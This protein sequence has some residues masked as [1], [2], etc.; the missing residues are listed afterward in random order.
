MIPRRLL[1]SGP[2]LGLLGLL[3]LFVVLLYL[4]GQLQAFFTASNIQV[5]LHKNSI[6]AVIALGA[7][8]VIVSGGIDLSVGS[9]AALVT[10]VIMQVYRLVYDGPDVVLPDWLLEWLRERG[11]AWSGTSSAVWASLVAVPAGLLTGALCGLTNGLVVTRLRLTPFVATLGMMSL[12]RGVA[13]WLSGRTRISFSGAQP[14]WVKALSRSA[15][16]FLFFEPGVWLALAL[17]GVVLLLMQVTVFGRHVY[18]I[19]SNEATARLCGVPVGRDK[20]WVYV[21]AGLL[22]ALGGVL[23]FAHG[24]GG[25]PDA[26]KMLELEVIAAVVIGGASLSGGQGGVGGTLL[27]VLILAVLENGLGYLDVPVELKHV[28]IGVIV[29]ANTALSLWQRRQRE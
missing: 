17:A 18:A 29:V 10:V 22:T 25:D 4:R 26:G 11:L 19:G 21:I 24:N 9:V 12:A 16:D 15:N 20:T 1:P 7:L 28:L 13:I 8:L 27:G 2:V 6:A 3:L 23:L 14:D 5:L